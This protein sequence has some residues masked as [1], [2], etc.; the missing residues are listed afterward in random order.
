MADA[1]LMQFVTEPL[2]QFGLAG[3][4]IAYCLFTDFTTRRQTR[5]MES[6]RIKR[7]EERERKAEKREQDCIDRYTEL[8]R[9]HKQELLVTLTRSNQLME[10]LIQDRGISTYKTPLPE[11]KV[12]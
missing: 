12:P 10:L 3:C 4:I 9:R 6:A 7:E 2:V 1:S 11:V 8:E 5:E